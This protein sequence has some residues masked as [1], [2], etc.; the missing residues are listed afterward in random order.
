MKKLKNGF[1]FHISRIEPQ[2]GIFQKIEI[3]KFTQ[4]KISRL[5][6]KEVKR[7]IFVI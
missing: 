5:N 2:I 4:K 7:P 6:D 3:K 1:Y